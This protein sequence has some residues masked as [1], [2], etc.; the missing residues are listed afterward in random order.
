MAKSVE[1]TTVEE[2]VNTFSEVQWQHDPENNVLIF[3]EKANAWVP[4]VPG[5]F[6][7]NIAKRYE[8]R[9]EPAPA[10]KTTKKK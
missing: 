5:Q 10:R 4:V 1:F 2:L 9:D 3:D 6:V 7:V 8:V